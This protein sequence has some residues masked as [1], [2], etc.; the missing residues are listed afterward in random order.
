[1]SLH[2]KNDIWIRN[3]DLGS[4]NVLGSGETREETIAL[5]ETE[6]P[7]KGQELKVP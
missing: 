3:K 1:M 6:R 4:I 5:R 2:L 7:G